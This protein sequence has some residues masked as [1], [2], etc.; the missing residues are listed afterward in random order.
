MFTGEKAYM[1][2]ATIFPQGYESEDYQVY[3]LVRV[4][5]FIGSYSDL[6][7][8]AQVKMDST[9]QHNLL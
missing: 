9:V 8:S 2:A 4:S 3:I 7:I 6:E 1:D 5:D